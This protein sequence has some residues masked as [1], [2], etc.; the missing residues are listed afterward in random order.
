[1]Y[2]LAMLSAKVRAGV[3]LAQR[4]RVARRLTLVVAHNLAEVQE[5]VQLQWPVLLLR[6]GADHAHAKGVGEVAAERVGLVAHAQAADLESSHGV[7]TAEEG[8]VGEVRLALAL[9]QGVE[10]GRERRDGDELVSVEQ[11]Q[12]N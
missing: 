10:D 12:D 11:E 7:W 2:I 5:R 8:A 9:P 1:M 6:N 4:S 3:S